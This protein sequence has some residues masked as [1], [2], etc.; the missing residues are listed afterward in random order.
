MSDLTQQLVDLGRELTVPVRNDLAERVLARLDQPAPRSRRWRR[1]VLALVA[2]L[3]ALAVSAAVSAPVRAAIVHVFRFGGVEV[4]PGPG[5][6]PA[7]SPTLPGQHTTDLAAAGQEAGFTVRV[8]AALGLP[9]SITVGGNRVVSLHYTARGNPVQVDEFAGGLG[10]MWEK[11]IGSGLAKQVSFD[12]HSA[13]WFDDPT[14]TM[15]VGPN[16]P[17]PGSARA[18]NGTLVWTDGGI[19]YRLDGVRPMTA[20]IEVAKSMK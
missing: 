16:G 5:P 17:D 10:V 15:Y 1:L 13:L 18:M 2:M 12:G 19:T 3:A 8:P 4:R 9:E 20:A 11:F 7:T 14:L 6:T